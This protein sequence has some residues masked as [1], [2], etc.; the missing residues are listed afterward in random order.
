MIAQNNKFSFLLS[1][2][3]YEVLH[4]IL[5]RAQEEIGMMLFCRKEMT[6]DSKLNT[7]EEHRKW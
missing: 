4:I 3:E 2:F 5:K 7:Q 6:P 1:G